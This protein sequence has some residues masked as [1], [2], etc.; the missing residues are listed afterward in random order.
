[1]DKDN[2]HQATESS[3]MQM[4]SKVMKITK[5]LNSLG[6]LSLINRRHISRKYL[7]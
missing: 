1:M 5:S 2:P 7:Q 4:I 3:K 6:N